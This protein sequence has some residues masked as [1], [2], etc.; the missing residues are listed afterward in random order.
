MRRGGLRCWLP[1]PLLTIF[2]SPSHSVLLTVNWLAM[3]QDALFPVWWP[4]KRCS[5][6][7]KR[8]P[9][10]SFI[11]SSGAASNSITAVLCLNKGSAFTTDLTVAGDGDVER[12]S[13]AEERN[14]ERSWT[15]GFK[16][17]DTVVFSGWDQALGKTMREEI[18][19]FKLAGRGLILV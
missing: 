6:A 2:L 18:F 8:R 3:L 11:T 5:K 12:G 1:Q 13:G 7:A 10:S 4:A 17:L 19:V 9:Y 16:W 14:Q 15:R